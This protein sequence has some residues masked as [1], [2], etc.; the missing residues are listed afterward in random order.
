MPPAMTADAREQLRI[1]ASGS[2]AIIPS[3]EFEKRLERSVSTGTPL[4]V[5]LGI[6]PSSP[7]IHLGHAVPLRKL[8]RFQDLGHVAVLIIGDFTGQ[9]GDPSGQSATRRALAPDEVATNAATYVDQARRILLPDR[10]E[11]RHNSEWLGSMGVD[12]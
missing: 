11:V 4:R 10:L 12:G 6:D 9:V 5:K 1:L 3:D 7:D 2:A 8:R